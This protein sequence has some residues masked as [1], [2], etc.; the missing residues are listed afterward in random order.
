MI[1]NIPTL[2][3]AQEGAIV[4]GSLGEDDES[5]RGRAKL[6]LASLVRCQPAAL[7]Y[8]AKSFV[9]ST[10]VSFKHARVFEDPER[11][12]YAELIVDDGSGMGGFVSDGAVI[13]DT[14]PSGGQAT[15][16]FESPAA[17]APE[18]YVGGVQQEFN[19]GP[20]PA[21]VVLEERGIMYLQKSEK[22][23]S[24]TA[25]ELKNYKVLTGP[26][27]E[28]QAVVEG[29]PKNP[30]GA[31]GWRAAGTRIRVLPPTIQFFELDLRVLLKSYSDIEKQK[32]QITDVVTE[33][34]S[35]LGPGDP[36]RFSPLCADVLNKVAAVTD[37][38]V[39]KPTGDRLEP[40]T[41]KHCLRLDLGLFDIIPGMV[42]D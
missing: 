1:T 26:L 18:L 32:A 5:L 2:S 11:P 35:N 6:Y 24:G 34:V 21:P 20:Y 16:F 17:D 30:L 36:L 29:D 25:W 33:F 27:R 19:P 41:P 23:S 39:Q 22:L 9:S 8:L 28:L 13:S 15:L 31:A 3:V 37:C 4:G 10:G 42:T 38:H 7:E 12:G 40:N 14:A